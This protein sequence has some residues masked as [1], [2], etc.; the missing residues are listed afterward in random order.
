MQRLLVL[1]SL[2]LLGACASSPNGAAQQLAG[3]YYFEQDETARELNLPWGVEL[4]SDSLSS[5]FLKGQE[6][7]RAAITLADPERTADFP[8]GYWQPLTEQ[9]LRLGYPG[10]GGFTVDL[11]VEGDA[12][13]GRIAGAGDVATGAP[14]LAARVRLTRARCPE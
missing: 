8:F 9:T 2:C 6:N 5:P 14:M 10:M 7:V 4:T 13:T 1:G 3:C 11:T 12:L